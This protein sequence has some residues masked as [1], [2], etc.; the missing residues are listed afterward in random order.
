MLVITFL[1]HQK[2]PILNVGITIFS[3]K[4]AF[5]FTFIMIIMT[6][7]KMILLQ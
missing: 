6:E 3:V 7:Y 2:L 5:N 1:N 4:K